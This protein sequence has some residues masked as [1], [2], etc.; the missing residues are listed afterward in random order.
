MIALNNILEVDSVILEFGERRVLSDIYMRF[1]TGKVTGIL[2]RNGA[3]KSCLLRMI[4]GTLNAQYSNVRF[5][6]KALFKTYQ[7]TEMI[8]YLPQKSFIP[9]FMRLQRILD[10]FTCDLHRFVNDFPEYAGRVMKPFRTFSFGQ[11][12]LIE[13][14]ILLNSPSDF[15]LL[16]EPFSYL[17][18]VHVEKLK[19]IIGVEKKKKGIV[20]T[21]HLYHDL[22][23]VTDDLYLITDGRSYSVKSP[24]DLRLHGYVS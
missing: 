4:F 16:D 21:D 7:H 18:P 8:K 17:M 23:D 10:V 19:Q 24:D 1:E 14:Y 9:G 12:R 13:T 22:L 5:N 11:K 6:H 2:G 20:I 15:I 3:G